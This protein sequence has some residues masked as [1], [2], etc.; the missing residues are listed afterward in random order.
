MGESGACAMTTVCNQFKSP[1]AGQTCDATG[2]VEWCTF[3]DTLCGCGQC[4]EGPC[5][6][7]PAQWACSGPPTTPGCPA[8]LPNSGAPCTSSGLECSYGYP[9]GGSGAV[10]ACQNGFW[11]W[12][13]IECPA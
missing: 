4:L 11:A 6:T 3:G 10:A 2:G 1:P 8:L 5:M 12:Q 9:C 7:N 13:T